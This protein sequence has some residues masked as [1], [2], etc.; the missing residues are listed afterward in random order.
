MNSFSACSKLAILAWFMSAST[1]FATPLAFIAGQFERPVSDDAGG[2][3]LLS[4][5]GKVASY[6]ITTGAVLETT[7]APGV[8]L[9]ISPDGT[10]LVA[11]NS[12]SPTGS[13]SQWLSI[14]DLLTRQRVDYEIPNTSLER[15]AS[16]VYADDHTLLFTTRWS[17]MTPLRRLDLLTGEVTEPF[18]VDEG[19]KNFLGASVKAN[20]DRAVVTILDPN[21]FSALFLRGASSTLQYARADYDAAWNRDGTQL[22]TA[23]L[24]GL[25]VYDRSLAKVG[26]IATDDD[27]DHVPASVVYSPVSDVLYVSTFSFYNHDRLPSEIIAYDANT[28]TKLG[29]IAT[30]PDAYYHT[31]SISRDGR[32]LF[33]QQF[34]A[35]SRF[36]IN[37]VRIFDVS[38]FA[39]PEPQTLVGVCFASAVSQL[40]RRRRR[41][42]VSQPVG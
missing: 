38:T 40:S 6:D 19:G 23:S 27:L 41:A 1:S 25:D 26:S 39:V 12:F 24:S 28:L 16:A 30:L 3:L 15:I 34:D 2:R 7:F 32:R 10:K 8:A 37:G 13:T 11:A 31:L 42:A 9:D 35:F 4:S 5:S 22:A 18:P 29:T 36:P 21:D 20:A 17:N 14:H 33:G